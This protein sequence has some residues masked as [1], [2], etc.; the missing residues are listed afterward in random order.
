MSLEPGL[1]SYA[2]LASLALSVKKHR[3]AKPF[4]FMPSSAMA[5]LA[6]WALLLLSLIISIWIF[7]DAQGVVAW[8]GQTCVAGSVFVLLMSWQSHR[9]ILLGAAA[10]MIAVPVTFIAG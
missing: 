8:I 2:A 6:G 4:A 7:G 3:P 1:I 9:A 10:L 5:R